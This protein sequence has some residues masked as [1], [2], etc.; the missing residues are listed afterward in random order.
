MIKNTQFFAK[1]RPWDAGK[2]G[3]AGPTQ[4]FVIVMVCPSSPYFVTRWVMSIHKSLFDIV[5]PSTLRKPE[6]RIP[7]SDTDRGDDTPVFVVSVLVFVVLYNIRSLFL[8]Q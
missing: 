8:F 5:R 1:V 3:L 4:K 7:E 2:L 6:K